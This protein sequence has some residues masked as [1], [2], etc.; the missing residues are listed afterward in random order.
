MH[1]QIDTVPAH[2]LEAG[3]VFN[4]EDDGYLTVVSTDDSGEEI[5]VTATDKFED[6]IEVSLIAI[7]DIPIFQEVDD[8]EEDA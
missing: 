5:I 3:D 7:L 4:T 2:T 6:E 1:K 8:D